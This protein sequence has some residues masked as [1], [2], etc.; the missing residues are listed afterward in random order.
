[1]INKKLEELI[2]NYSQNSSFWINFKKFPN[3]TL[4]EKKTFYAACFRQLGKAC[5]QD[6][7]PNETWLKQELSLDTANLHF[8]ELGRILYLIEY[9]DDEEFIHEILLRGNE[10]EQ[11][12]LIKVL[13]YLDNSEKYKNDLIN[14]C[15]SNSVSLYNAISQGNPYPSLYFDDNSF[16][17]LAIK[18]IFLNLTF[19]KI[20]GLDKRYT[21]TFGKILI[22]F[23]KERTVAK[24]TLPNDVI[25]FMK[26]KG[27][28]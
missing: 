28:L 17:N 23:Y 14:L 22:D 9:K 18:T 4:L 11:I 8:G 20:V 25:D 1:M 5:V 6:A 19:T 3:A 27:I 21:K 13:Q 2:H 24:R 7:F 26:T 16:Y 15:R 10:S 12:P